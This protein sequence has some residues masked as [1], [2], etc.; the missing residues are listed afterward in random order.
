M[1][2]GARI[3]LVT[4]SPGDPRR[5]NIKVRF[6]ILAVALAALVVAPAAAAT[7]T[8]YD[9]SYKSASAPTPAACKSVDTTH[10]GR[11]Q[12][13]PTT[14]PWQWQLQ[15]KIDTAVPACVYDVDAFEASKATVT[16]L[17]SEGVRVICYVDA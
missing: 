5:M 14:A 4:A 10:D 2:G 13:R 16:K 17:H 1:R 8:T 7:G 3:G 6:T 11:W 15:G 9:P 12:P